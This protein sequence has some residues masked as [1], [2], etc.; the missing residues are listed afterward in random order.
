MK[1]FRGVDNH[2]R[3]FRPMLNMERMHRS[4]KRCC[5]PV[6]L[7]TEGS[8]NHTSNHRYIQPTRKKIRLI[9][10]I[11]LRMILWCVFHS[12][13]LIKPSCCSASTSWW[14]WTRTGFLSPRTPASTSDPRLSALRWVWWS[15]NNPC[16][17]V[18]VSNGFLLPVQPSLGVSRAGKALIFVIVG[19]V[20]PYFATG[21]FSPVSLLADP[22]YVRAWKGGV[23]E[24]KM[25][26][27]VFIL[28]IQG[29]FMLPSSCTQKM[30]NSN[31]TVG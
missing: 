26:G 19:P 12:S 9:M 18:C 27:W 6:S 29:E 24:Y 4:T 31:F 28:L 11:I 23:G 25:G 8:S 21:S 1:A 7:C 10:W 16:S 5:L 20:G 15:V 3:L 22:A 13:C 14:R 30:G 17:A 2:I